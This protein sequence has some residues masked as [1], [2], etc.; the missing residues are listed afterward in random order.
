MTEYRLHTILPR[1]GLSGRL[2]GN[3]TIWKIPASDGRLC[4]VAAPLDHFDPGAPWNLTGPDSP[5]LSTSF[6]PS[7]LSFSLPRN[8]GVVY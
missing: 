5:S 1:S 7:L 4:V 3:L 2:E 8:D 6:L